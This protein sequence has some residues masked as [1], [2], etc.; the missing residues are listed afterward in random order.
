[1]KLTA[2]DGNL[3]RDSVTPYPAQRLPLC[4]ADQATSGERQPERKAAS[5]KGGRLR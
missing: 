5:G 1:M 3:A 4:C 2:D